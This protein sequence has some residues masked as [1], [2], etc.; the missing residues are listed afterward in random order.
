MSESNETKLR[1]ALQTI[2]TFPIP[3]Q[4][5][6]PAANMR[7]L[8]VA[9]LSAPSTETSGDQA[10]SDVRG[11]MHLIE[12]YA[13]D[14]IRCVADNDA[15]AAERARL[16]IA[17]MPALLARLGVSRLDES[18]SQPVATVQVTNEG[19][20]MRLSTYVAYALPEGKHDL[21]PAPQLVERKAQPVS[22]NGEI[23]FDGVDDTLEATR[24]REAGYKA[25]WAAAK[26]DSEWQSG[27]KTKLF[28]VDVLGDPMREYA[29][30]KWENA[31]WPSEQAHGKSEAVSLTNEQKSALFR[32]GDRL[33]EYALE[34]KKLG[35]DSTAEGCKASAY[36]MKAMVEAAECAQRA[37]PAADA[38]VVAEKLGETCMDDGKC[39][40]Q[41]KT[42]CF[43]RECCGP[44]S[45]SGLTMEQ[46]RYPS[47]STGDSVRVEGGEAMAE[48]TREGSRADWWFADNNL[49]VGTKLYTRPAASAPVVHPDAARLEAE[50]ARLNAIINQP[51][52]DDFVRAVSIEAEHQRQRWPSEHDAGKTPADWFW[53]VGY[54]AGKVLHLHAAGNIEKAE[55]HVITTGAACLNWHRAMFGKTNMRPGHEEGIDAPKATP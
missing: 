38:A 36:V 45:G 28:A 15:E 31:V 51:H 4:D 47:Q 22:D 20:V 40:H 3:Q 6:M 18:S 55:H 10:P 11:V 53:L 34:L 2:A 37:A 49:P 48:R 54:L 43:R 44:L 46:W 27:G 8:A 17:N 19:Y 41:C 35:Q 52:A 30:G 9:A 13:A 23:R 50:V 1:A 21:Y 26:R 29:P 33:E 16:S 14:M 5:D 24:V 32:G 12:G 7:A 25:G 39:H 42:R